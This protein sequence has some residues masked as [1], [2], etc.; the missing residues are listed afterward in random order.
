MLG[1]FLCSNAALFALS[2]L[3]QVKND[4]PYP[5]EPINIHIPAWA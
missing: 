1:V 3:H 2:L 5:N 4:W